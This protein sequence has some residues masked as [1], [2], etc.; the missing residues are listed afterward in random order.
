MLLLPPLPPVALPLEA[1]EVAPPPAPPREQVL[2]GVEPDTH[3]A[4]VLV[5]ADWTMKPTITANTRWPEDE[6]GRNSVSP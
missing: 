2:P 1:D 3:F 6:T 5:A 4:Q